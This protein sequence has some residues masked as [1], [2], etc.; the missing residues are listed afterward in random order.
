MRPRRLTPSPTKGKW[1]RLLVSSAQYVLSSL[2]LSLLLRVR[3]TTPPCIGHLPTPR[4]APPPLA[5]ATSFASIDEFIDGL[6]PAPPPPCRLAK[7]GNKFMKDS[8]ASVTAQQNRL[9]RSQSAPPARMGCTRHALAIE[10]AGS[11]QPV[12]RTRRAR[13]APAWEQGAGGIPQC[14]V[15]EDAALRPGHTQGSNPEL[16]PGTYGNDRF[17][18]LHKDR[19]GGLAAIGDR[20]HTLWD[21]HLF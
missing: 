18:A 10:K 8:L 16:G 9:R 13:L 7:Q 14:L 15:Y 2:S 21:M 3:R 19:F 12:F 17:G 11:P 5:K 20:A 1:P 6:P 4:A